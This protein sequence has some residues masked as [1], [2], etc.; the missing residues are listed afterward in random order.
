MTIAQDVT[1]ASRTLRLHKVGSPHPVEAIVVRRRDPLLELV[2][3]ELV[4]RLHHGGRGGHEPSASGESGRRRVRRLGR[5]RRRWLAKLVLVE[6]LVVELG[7][8]VVVI[9]V[10]VAVVGVM[11]A[12]SHTVVG[13]RRGRGARALVVGARHFKRF[14]GH[15]H[16]GLAEHPLDD[17]GVGPLVLLTV[18][19][20][21]APR[22]FVLS[23]PATK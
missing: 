1:S 23:K 11:A 13:G 6:V 10:E 14:A 17:R 15:V 22:T 8:V 21:G 20:Q 4:G 18:P 9:V 2:L 16:L 19:E 12:A 5:Q 3:V 7:Q